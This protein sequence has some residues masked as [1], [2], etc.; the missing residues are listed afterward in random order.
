M[1]SCVCGS[2]LEFSNGGIGV[3]AELESLPESHIISSST[4]VLERVVANFLL[5][6]AHA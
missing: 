2:V 1:G 3:L 5:S 4:V 6:A